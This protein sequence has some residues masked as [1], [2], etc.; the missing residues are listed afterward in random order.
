MWKNVHLVWCRDSNSRP[1]EH[2]SP[3]ITTRPGLPPSAIPVWYNI[4]FTC[5][6]SWVMKST[7]V[8]RSL[9][10]FSLYI[11]TTT[12][13]TECYCDKFIQDSTHNNNNKNNNNNNNAT[14]RKRRGSIWSIIMRERERGLR[15]NVFHKASLGTV[16]GFL[17]YFALSSCGPTL[18]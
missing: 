7:S 1:L 16:A 17:F 10:L 2:E 9:S 8:T 15:L 4:W 11:T 12:T 18:S 13:K 6:V 14:Q 3:P 5:C